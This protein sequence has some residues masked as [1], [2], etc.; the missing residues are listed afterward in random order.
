MQCGSFSDVLG[1]RVG[2]IFKVQ[3]VQEEESQQENA[4]FISGRCGR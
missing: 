1:L 3:E 2:P 4:Q